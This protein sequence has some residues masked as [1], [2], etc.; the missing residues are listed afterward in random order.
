[1]PTEMQQGLQAAGNDNA[2]TMV[3]DG[4][5][6]AQQ[7]LLDK[8][9]A[10]LECPLATTD[11]QQHPMQ[12]MFDAAVASMP[13]VTHFAA[14]ARDVCIRIAFPRYM[15]EVSDE[16]TKHVIKMHTA[17]CNSVAAASDTAG[18]AHAP[19]AQVAAAAAPQNTTATAA[20]VISMASKMQ[21][22]EADVQRLSAA[23]PQPARRAAP[24]LGQHPAGVATALP[25]LAATRPRPSL[26]LVQ[27]PSVRCRAA[28]RSRS[29][30]LGCERHL[31]SGGGPRG[32]PN[33]PP[34]SRRRP[35]CP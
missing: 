13:Q 28:S 17:S 15:Q 12:E 24:A 19:A 5:K 2:T 35:R 7:T 6:L 25:P 32:P 9:V 3:L 23:P 18:I 10:E 22:L 14:A 4:L 11:W 33:A 20:D 34:R 8:H 1:M 26:V 21:K 31:A 27:E 29:A 16:L 30:G